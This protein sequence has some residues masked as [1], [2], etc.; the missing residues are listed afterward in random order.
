MR[1]RSLRDIVCCSYNTASQDGM[2]ARCHHAGNA[3]KE[4]VF[5]FVHARAIFVDY[6]PNCQVE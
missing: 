6:F 2:H 4:E 1:R 3:F 5:C